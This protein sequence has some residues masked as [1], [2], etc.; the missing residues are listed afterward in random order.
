MSAGVLAAIFGSSF[1][2]SLSGALSPGPLTT[3]A[4]QEGARRGFWAGPLLASG[5]GAIELALVIAVAQGLDRV[6]DEE[7]AAIAIALVGGLFLLWLGWRTL[8]SAPRQTLYIGSQDEHKGRPVDHNDLLRR[9]ALPLMVAGVAVSVT[10]PFWLVWWVTIGTA[11]IAEALE[12]GAAGLVSFYSAHI[13]TDLVWLSLIAFL[14]ARG[15]R[16]FSRWAYRGVLMG[17]GVFL[18]AL[19]GWFLADGIGRAF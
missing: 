18:L 8:R 4:I 12:Q 17:C 14:L 3:L 15:R 2:V 10:N 11:Y 19:G 16:F 7:A 5:H 1:L 13:L 6:L 9:S